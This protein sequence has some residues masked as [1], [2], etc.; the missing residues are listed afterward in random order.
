MLGRII[1][2]SHPRARAMRCDV[3]LPR[4]VFQPRL[5]GPLGGLI[6]V[7]LGGLIKSVTNLALLLLTS[8]LTTYANGIGDEI[9]GVGKDLP[10]P[11]FR[12]MIGELGLLR[13]TRV[14]C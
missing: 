10:L 8:L 13:N 2:R 1:P 5:E 12:A 4:T 14:A 3:L 6:L 9:A 7:P 11:R